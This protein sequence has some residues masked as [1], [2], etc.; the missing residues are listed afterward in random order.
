MF[1]PWLPPRSK[2]AKVTGGTT[3]PATPKAG[4]AAPV[5]VEVIPVK[6]E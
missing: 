2:D 6:R 3:G 5:V 1:I 4:A